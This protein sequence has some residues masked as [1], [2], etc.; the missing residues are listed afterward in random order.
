MFFR[1]VARITYLQPLYYVP[2][3]NVIAHTLSYTF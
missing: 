1:C 2:V 3:V